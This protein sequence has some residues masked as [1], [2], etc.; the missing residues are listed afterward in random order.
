MNCSYSAKG[1][2]VTDYIPT[3]SWC[4]GQRHV[5]VSATCVS[6]T[7]DEGLQTLYRTPDIGRI[8]SRRGAT[9]LHTSPAPYGEME[10]GLHRSQPDSYDVEL[11]VTDPGTA[12]EV[13]P[14]RGQARIS[15][16][17]LLVL[18]D[19]AADYGRRS[20]CGS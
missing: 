16:D 9:I 11:R 19:S 18:E 10:V 3:Y 7:C 15:L 8:I 20:G 13:A 5:C 12:G 14:A 4:Q 17:E 2:N 1:A 6:A